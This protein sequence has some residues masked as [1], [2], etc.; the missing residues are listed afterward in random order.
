MQSDYALLAEN[1]A[2][3]RAKK[4]YYDIARFRHLYTALVFASRF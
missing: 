2:C 1:D 4:R 3:E